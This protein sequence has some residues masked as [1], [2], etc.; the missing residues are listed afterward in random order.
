MGRELAAFA[1]RHPRSRALHERART[2]APR[3]RPDELDGQVGGAASRSSSTRPRAPTSRTSTGH[4]YVDFC[5]GDT[6]AMAGH[7]PEATVRAVERQLR[8][9]DHPHAP[10]RGRDRRGRRAPP[11][12]RRSATGSS[13]SPRPTRTGSPSASRREI[14]GPTEGRRP[15]P[16]LPRLRGRDVRVAHARRASRGPARERRPARGSRR[17]PRASSPFNDLDGAGARAG[18]WRRRRARCSSPR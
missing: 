3:R 10:D 7:G 2:V 14:T 12:V 18:P 13:P 8:P 9:R 16:Q 4:E 6:G 15:R 1:E 17:S 5:L 11:P